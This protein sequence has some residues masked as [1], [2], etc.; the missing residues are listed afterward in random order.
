[1]SNRE[2]LI[3]YKQNI[4]PYLRELHALSL[5]VPSERDLL[6]LEATEEVRGN[7][8]EALKGKPV[9][10][11]RIDF[12]EKNTDR[13]KSY[14]ANLHRVNASPVYIWISKT[15]SCGL[16]AISSLLQF[17]FDFPFDVIREGIIGLLSSDLSDTLTLDFSYDE[18]SFKYELEIDIFGDH[19][20]LIEY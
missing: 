10:K 3:R 15:N 5:E 6:T 19:W 7:S 16:Y 13:F 12:D 17:N 20:A 11:V 9:R 4:K 18:K 1:M 14:V 2:R 8:K